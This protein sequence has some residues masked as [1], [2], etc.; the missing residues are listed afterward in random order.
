MESSS[1]DECV[2]VGKQRHVKIG[3]FNEIS[4]VI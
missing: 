2:I 1:E 3:K 4:N